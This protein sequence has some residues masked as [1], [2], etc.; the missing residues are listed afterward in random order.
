MLQWC[1]DNSDSMEVS[2]H[3]GLFSYS[4]YITIYTQLHMLYMSME[5]M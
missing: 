3:V 2:L 5:E 1:V 4:L